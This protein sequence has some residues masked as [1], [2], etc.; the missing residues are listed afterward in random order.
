MLILAKILM[1]FP[2]ST[3]SDINDKFRHIKTKKGPD[4]TS[5]PSL[6]E[7]SIQISNVKYTRRDFIEMCNL[8][9]FLNSKN[10]LIFII[11]L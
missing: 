1:H 7:C 4:Y 3:D 2:S 9:K 5:G 10:A 8:V 6:V 11:I